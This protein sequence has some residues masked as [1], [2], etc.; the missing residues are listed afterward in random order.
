MSDVSI[1][2]LS[3]FEAR[4]NAQKISREGED[5]AFEADEDARKELVETLELPGVSAVS[6]KLEIRRGPYR[7]WRVTGTILA[8]LSQVCVVSLEPFDVKVETELAVNFVPENEFESIAA[9]AE[10][11][12]AEDIEP[13][14]NGDIPIGALIRDTI[15]LSLDPYPRKPGVEL[16]EGFGDEEKTPSPFAALQQLKDR[17]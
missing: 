10:D 2:R 6:A 5:I 1:V 16:P 8:D 4:L 14:E 9:H 3:S 7:G 13:F 11:E 12:E 17:G 15:S